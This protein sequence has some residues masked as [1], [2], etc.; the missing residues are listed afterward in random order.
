MVPMLVP[1]SSIVFISFLHSRPRLFQRDGLVA[2][3]AGDFV[4][5][6]GACLDP[7]IGIEV[8]LPL[9]FG[10]VLAVRLAKQLQLLGA[11]LEGSVECVEVRSCALCWGD[12]GEDDG[13]PSGLSG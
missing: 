4:R 1:I 11:E 13:S 3:C 10:H 5:L 12:R 7:S 6:D 9:Q 2:A 8:C